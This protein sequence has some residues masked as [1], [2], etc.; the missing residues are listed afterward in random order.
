VTYAPD[1]E[2]LNERL[3][4][5]TQAGEAW[6]C[7]RCATF[8]VG[9]PHG[10]GPADQAPLVLRGTALKDA[11]VL[12][13]LAA[14]RVVRAVVLL[15]LAYGVQYF[16][17]SQT[18]VQAAFEKFVPA[19]EPLARLFNYDL[20]TSPTVERVRHLLGSS[21][22]TLTWVTVGL[23]LYGG[24][25]LLEGVGLW[26][27]KRWGEYVAVVATSAFLPVEVYELS[28]H[29]T[30]VKVAALVVN[31]VAVAYLVW[32]KR[33]FGFRGGHAAF[34]AE[35]ASQSLLEVE[36]AALTEGGKKLVLQ[37]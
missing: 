35:R 16:A 5:D 12:R 25:Q 1:E 10:S 8:V 30:W 18:S 26:M 24:L 17:S 13:L 11:T 33:L 19:A 20:D 9:A 6:R 14:E 2:A 27:L 23:V 37:P 15:L 3:R 34:E 29:V 4:V 21:H 22:Q 7:L 32:T 28:H 36:A 31:L